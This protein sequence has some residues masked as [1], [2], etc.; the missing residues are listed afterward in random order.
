MEVIAVVTVNL[1]RPV[2]YK[3][4][5]SLNRLEDIGGSGSEIPSN[6]KGSTVLVKL[7]CV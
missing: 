2:P 7:G 5:S 6:L 3:F 1:G 4:N